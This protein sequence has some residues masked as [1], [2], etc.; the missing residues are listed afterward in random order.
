MKQKNS[1]FTASG[2]VRP[3]IC[4]GDKWQDK[5]GGVITVTGYEYNRVTYLREGYEHPCIYPVDRFRREFTQVSKAPPA[6]CSDIDRIMRVTGAER[7]R[8]VHEIIRERRR[9]E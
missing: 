4:P 6:E 3:E 7:I 2:P 9:T 5:S 1:G 8:A